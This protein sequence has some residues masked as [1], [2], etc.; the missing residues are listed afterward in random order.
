M[1]AQASDE[2]GAAAGPSPRLSLEGGCC[3]ASDASAQR[4]CVGGRTS[5]TRVLPVCICVHTHSGFSLGTLAVVY[6]VVANTEL[7]STEPCF[8]KIY[9]FI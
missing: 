9:L 2:E 5:C 8:L 3:P 6:P 7:L 4:E 1:A